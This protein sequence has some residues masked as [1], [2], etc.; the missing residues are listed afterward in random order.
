MI[1]HPPEL[2]VVLRDTGEDL[3]D[4]ALPIHGVDANVASDYR[5]RGEPAWLRRVVSVGPSRRS[6]VH[7]GRLCCLHTAHTVDELP[8]LY[9]MSP[10]VRLHASVHVHVCASARYQ[11]AVV[12]CGAGLG[13]RQA[14]RRVR[15]CVLGCTER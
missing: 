8:V 15:P 13:G 10:K 5:C 6:F 4:D 11:R 3:C 7:V 14:T 9:I 2:R 1:A 12:V